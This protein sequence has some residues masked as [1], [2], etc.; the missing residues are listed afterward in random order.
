M[1]AVTYPLTL[2]RPTTIDAGSAKITSSNVAELT[3]TYDPPEWASGTYAI[4][5][6]RAKASLHKIYQARTAGVLSTSPESDS[7]NW[8]EVGATNKWKPFDGKYQ[9][10]AQNADSIVYTIQP[11]EFADS[12][13]VGNC[14]GVSARLE[15]ADFDQTINMQSRTVRDMWEHLTE[16]FNFRKDAV[17]LNVPFGLSN[18]ATLTITN[19]GGVAK[20]GEIKVG[21][22]RKLGLPKWGPRRG[23]IDYSPPTTDQWGNVTATQ[24]AYA[25]RMTM[26]VEVANDF[27]D[28][29]VRILESYRSTAAVWLG[30]SDLYEHLIVYGYYE[31]FETV[32][33]LPTKSTLQIQFRG[34]T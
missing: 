19:T 3:T 25:K 5:D 12:L 10:Q 15:C 4:G 14:E 1:P 11:N 18:S 8:A 21:L 9:A 22:S 32:V 13:W 6:Q 29:L 24:G 30:A 28:E 2:I 20:C 23:I 31:S 16:P 33:A 34:L 26:D 7:T 17:F 27:I